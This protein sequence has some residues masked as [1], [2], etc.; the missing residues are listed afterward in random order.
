MRLEWRGAFVVSLNLQ[1]SPVRVVMLG[2]FVAGVV[3]LIAVPW[4]LG[5]LLSVLLTGILIYRDPSLALRRRLGV[6]LGC[7]VVLGCCD[8][9]TSTTV[10][11]FLAV[12]IPFGLVV[13]LPALLLRRTDPGVIRFRFWPERW[14]RADVLYTLLSVPLAW[15]VL[16]GYWAVNPDLFTHWVL[17]A[18]MDEGEIRRLF[19]GI[20][21]VGIWD[22]LFFVNTAFAILRSL[23]RFP[24]ANAVQA[25][26][27]TAV[28]YDMA[29]TGIGPLVIYA[30][31]WTQGAMFEKSESLLWVLLVHL[32]VDYFLVAAIVGSYYPGIGM[33]YL[34]AHGF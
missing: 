2:A 31:A 3:F 28:L 10:S 20:N 24:V 12:G 8:I 14:R 4:L 29:F 26:V 5:G 23:F 34:W 21:M 1:L 25:V 7:V 32:I 18:E 13:L 15:V 22:E 19:L 11:N 17:P 16:K 9:N 27:Y 33:G 6:L 30:F